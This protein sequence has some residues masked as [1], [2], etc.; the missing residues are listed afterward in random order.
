[1]SNTLTTRVNQ[2]PKLARL[3]LV[4]DQPHHTGASQPVTCLGNFAKAVGVTAAGGAAGYALG[5][6][7]N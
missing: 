2:D 5:H 1:M 7:I 4:A 6:V 3:E